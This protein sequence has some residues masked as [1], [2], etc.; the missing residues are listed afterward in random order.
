MVNFRLE[1]IPFLLFLILSLSSCAHRSVSCST[2]GREQAANRLSVHA[3]CPKSG[4]SFRGSEG[5]SCGSN[6]QCETSPGQG[7]GRQ[8]RLSTA[9]CSVAWKTTALPDQAEG[10]RETELRAEVRLHQSQPQWVRQRGRWWRSLFGVLFP[11]PP[12]N[13]SESSLWESDSTAAKGCG[14]SGWLR[15]R[16]SPWPLSS[17]PIRRGF[18]TFRWSLAPSWGPAR[19]E[20]DHG[21]CDKLRKSRN[22]RTQSWEDCLCCYFDVV[23][24]KLESCISRWKLN[25]IHM[26]CV[27]CTP[28][29]TLWNPGL[30]LWQ[31][32]LPKKCFFNTC[33]SEMLDAS[34]Q[35]K[36]SSFLKSMLTVV[37]AFARK[38]N[39]V[40]WKA[41]RLSV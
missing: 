30:T 39:N 35:W 17:W 37:V 5:P 31:L 22:V 29:S 33:L 10:C 15:K 12:Q 9:P 4:H 28:I 25:R 20:V 41:A 19:W 23:I 32:W 18:S 24:G 8:Y 13:P 21:W 26:K 3:R 34:I 7:E 1:K 16:L 2:G 14:G 6:P 11:L 36:V 38:R 27:I 40:W